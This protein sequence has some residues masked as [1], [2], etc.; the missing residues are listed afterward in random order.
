MFFIIIICTASQDNIVLE[1]TEPD[2]DSIPCPG[3]TV[4]YNC[5]VLVGSDS[6]A[7]S[8]P[9]GQTMDLRFNVGS[10][11]GTERTS[12][13]GN[14][15]ATLT[16]RTGQDLNVMFDSTLMIREA[17]NYSMNLTCTAAIGGGVVTRNTM[18]VVSGKQVYNIT[19]QGCTIYTIYVHVPFSCCGTYVEFPLETTAE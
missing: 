13:D 15:I 14:F 17:M 4:V 10:P 12:E 16:S 19:F 3:Q 18:I 6:L 11:N 1:R 7:W 5:Q 9:N 2:D 8:L